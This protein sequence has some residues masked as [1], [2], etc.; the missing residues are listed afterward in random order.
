MFEEALV[1]TLGPLHCF[2][3]AICFFFVLHVLCTLL[4][5]SCC[6]AAEAEFRAAFILHFLRWCWRG[7]ANCKTNA[8]LETEAGENAK[9]AS[10]ET[11]VSPDLITL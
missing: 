9:H 4:L 8:N 2:A 5:R 11:A 3:C 10:L 1:A 6:V 7:P